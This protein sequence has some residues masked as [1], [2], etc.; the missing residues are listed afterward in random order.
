MN[1][2]GY[3]LTI[4]TPKGGKEKRFA[5]RL[6]EVHVILATCEWTEVNIKSVGTREESV[7]RSKAT[8]PVVCVE[9]GERFES[10]RECS[11][12]FGIPYKA[13]W[14]SMV[15]GNPRQGYHFTDVKPEENE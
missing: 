15:Y 13:I 8:R 11:K 2:S 1:I 5:K 7:E 10:I 14:N 4:T 9:T 3:F 12:H 6:G